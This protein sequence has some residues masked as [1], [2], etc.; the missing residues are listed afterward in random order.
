MKDQ[1][2]R[3]E[4]IKRQKASENPEVD[5]NDSSESEELDFAGFGSTNRKVAKKPT[6]A[7]QKPKK[8]F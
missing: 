2:E 1:L 8:T 6:P 5:E 4:K 7:A 3:Q